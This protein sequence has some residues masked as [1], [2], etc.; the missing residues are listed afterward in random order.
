MRILVYEPGFS[1]HR[2]TYVR[3]IIT[4]L[5]ELAQAAPSVRIILSTPAEG[6][7]TPA[8]AHQLAP[9][10]DS[11]E[12][13]ADAPSIHGL[14][15]WEAARTAGQP[16]AEIT[17]Q[18][19]ADHLLVPYGD[20]LIAWLGAQRYRFGSSLQALRRAGLMTETL[21][22]GGGVAYAGGLTGA[23]RRLAWSVLVARTP[24]DR[25]HYLDEQIRTLPHVPGLHRR[26][27]PLPDPVEPGSVLS[28]SAARLALGLSESGRL[29]ACVG[30]QD[31]RKGVD[32]LVHAFAHAK[33]AGLLGSADRLLLAGRLS[34]AVNSALALVR[35]ASP[36]LAPDIVTLDRYLS[37]LELAQALCAADVAAALYPHHL[38]SASLV[39]RAAAAQRM[40][41]GS[42]TGW[43]GRTVPRFGLGMTTPVSDTPTVA[44]ALARALDIAQT[45]QPSDAT[46]RFAAF[47]TPAGFA[48]GW[49]ALL[50]ARLGLAPLA[51]PAPPPMDPLHPHDPAACP[52]DV[53]P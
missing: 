22:L 51:A 28:R 7:N 36:A 9:L 20:G 35:A 26:L 33:S 19:R 41:L 29:I 52:P 5:R 37:D 11:F 44:A 30:A 13:R 6:V 14:I 50:R 8:F 15:G 21:L 4:A 25:I 39:I 40:T 45:W 34:P 46:R 48:A 2:Y 10:R 27:S 16:L 3:L 12:L 43:I 24:F 18:A 17:R 1:G 49:T 31:E 47:N 53:H 32:R 23:T 38:A 42:D